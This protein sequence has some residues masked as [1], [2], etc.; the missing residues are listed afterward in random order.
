MNNEYD[1]ARNIY[2]T[3]SDLVKVLFIESNPTPGKLILNLMNIFQT[4]S[5]RLPL[6]S[7]R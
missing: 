4:S 3:I 5:V 7:V 2:K 1:D 6:T